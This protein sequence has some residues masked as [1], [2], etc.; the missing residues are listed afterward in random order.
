MP[1]MS[2]LFALKPKAKENGFPCE[3][4]SLSFFKNHPLNKNSPRLALA[5]ASDEM[6]AELF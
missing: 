5:T 6:L 4:L 1:R 2:D 3:Y